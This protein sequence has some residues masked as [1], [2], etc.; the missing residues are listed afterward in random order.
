MQQKEG[1]ARVRRLRWIIW[2]TLCIAFVISIFQRTAL[3][4]MADQLMAAFGVGAAAFGG[5]VAMYFYVYTVMQIPAG[6]LVDYLGPRRTATAGL[7]VA[8]LASLLFAVAPGLGLAYVARFL[9]ALGVSVLFIAV[10]KVQATWFHSSEFGVISGLMV[11]IACLGMVLA[12][13]PLALLTEAL[14]W[15]GVFV[16]TGAVTLAVGAAAWLLVRDRPADLGLPA[17]EELP[18]AAPQTGIWASISQV[19]RTR[20]TWS[21]FFAFFGFYGANITFI[22]MWSVPYL[23]HGFGLDRP[24]A[25][26]FVMLSTLGSLSGGPVFGYLTDRAMARRRAPY[27]LGI[28]IYILTW[29]PLLWL[30]ADARLLPWLGPLFFIQGF[31]WSSFLISFALAKEVNHP[32]LAGIATGTVNSAGFLCA[33]LL[34]PLLGWLLDA[35][36]TGTL[37]DGARIYPMAAYQV[38]IAVTVACCILGL[39]ALL[40]TPET[41]CQNIYARAAARSTV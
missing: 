22:S 32:A 8:G 41:R 26:G 12:T 29:L 27:A 39:G 16:L 14:G 18:A 10:I 31:G 3:A 7:L 6:V 24:A 5:L 36:W 17:P 25:A 2:A 4:V 19:L 37:L 33:A 23:M 21:V 40:M 15:Q 20:T 11:L 30:G 13:V 9:I 34:Q 38:L 35:M 1:R 28:V